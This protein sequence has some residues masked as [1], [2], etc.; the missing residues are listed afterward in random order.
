M[1][2][3]AVNFVFECKDDNGVDLSGVRAQEMDAFIG[4][5]GPGDEPPSLIRVKADRTLVNSH[6]GVMYDP[7]AAGNE[8]IFAYPTIRRGEHR[9]MDVGMKVV[10]GEAVVLRLMSQNDPELEGEA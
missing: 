8:D 7:K 5:G 10:N 6:T 2:M 9:F 4:Y 3:Y 1:G